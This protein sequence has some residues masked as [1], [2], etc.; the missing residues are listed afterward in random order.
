MPLDGKMSVKLQRLI[1]ASLCVL[2]VFTVLLAIVPIP[3]NIETYALEIAVA[4]ASHIA[5]RTVRIQGWYSFNFLANWHGF[6]G[7]IEIAGHPETNSPLVSPPLRLS[8]AS[9]E[10]RRFGAVRSELLFY[11]SMQ[12]PTIPPG[13]VVEVYDRLPFG[14]IYTK[15]FFRE[16][17]IAIANEKGSIRLSQAPLLVVGAKTR[18][19]ALAVTLRL[20][21]ALYAE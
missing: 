20:L 17:L 10:N 5:E 14:V 3:I 15:S 8:P 6:R 21:P 13:T 9:F 18:E 1:I 12:I 16:S 11:E 19:E 4:D 7:T 2:V